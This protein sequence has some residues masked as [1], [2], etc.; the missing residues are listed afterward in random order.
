[1]TFEDL[2]TTMLIDY[3]L[4]FTFFKKESI[5]RTYRKYYP[6]PRFLSASRLYDRVVRIAKANIE[7][8]TSLFAEITASIAILLDCQ[9]TLYTCQS[10]LIIKSHYLD[11][12]QHTRIYLLSFIPLRN[13]HTS[14]RLSK[15]VYETLQQYSI[16]DR[17][18]SITCDN[19]R[20]NKT[21]YRALVRTVIKVRE[22]LLLLAI[23]IAPKITILTQLVDDSNFKSEPNDYEDILIA[24]LCLVH[25]IQ[26]APK[27]LLSKLSLVLKND[28]VKKNQ[29]DSK[30]FKGLTSINPIQVVVTRIS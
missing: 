15:H 27:A 26:L 22:K 25:V 23:G 29:D 7:L 13:R 11:S 8:I 2:Q 1:M 10:Y 17:I 19:A 9:S 24:T 20:N 18:L 12:N 5:R 16:E 14:V 4:P 6:N 28:E 21:F 3:G 30:G